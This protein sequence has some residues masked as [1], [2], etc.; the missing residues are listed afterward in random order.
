M[1]SPC[2]ARHFGGGAGLLPAVVHRHQR[3]VQRSV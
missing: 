2:L 1:N 3:G